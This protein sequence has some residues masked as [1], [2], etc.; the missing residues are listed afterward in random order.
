MH[1]IALKCFSMMAIADKNDKWASYAG[2]GGWNG[3][4][5]RPVNTSSNQHAFT[6]MSCNLRHAG[7]RKW[8]DDNRR[9]P[10]PFQHMGFSEGNDMPSFELSVI[11]VNQGQEQKYPTKLC[12]PLTR[13]PS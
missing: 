13:H 3:R 12:T 9:V 10:L 6:W 8:G 1:P 4:S 7:S 11:A 2:P 5:F